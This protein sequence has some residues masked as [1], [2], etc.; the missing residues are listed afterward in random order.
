[1]SIDP[2]IKYFRPEQFIPKIG[3][4]IMD[5]QEITNSRIGDPGGFCALWCI[6]YVDQRLTYYTYDRKKLI[7]YLFANIK[8]QRLSYRNL[9]RNYSRNILIHRDKLL[10]KINIDINDWINDN[11][12]NNQYDKFLAILMEEINNCCV[13]KNK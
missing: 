8:L 2:E 10:K 5:S 6:W 13:V 3:F 11:L 9:I 1:M 7:K 4:Q 12:T